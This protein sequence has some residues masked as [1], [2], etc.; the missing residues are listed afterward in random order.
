[1]TTNLWLKGQFGMNFLTDR[2]KCKLTTKIFS[3]VIIEQGI[4]RVNQDFPK[5]PAKCRGFV[6]EL[7]CKV[8]LTFFLEENRLRFEPAKL[9]AD[10]PK[11]TVQDFC[12]KDE[13]SR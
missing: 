2:K 1:M 10:E 8:K 11:K 13:Y 5:S 9:K 3:R 7:N 4:K 12:R 6:K